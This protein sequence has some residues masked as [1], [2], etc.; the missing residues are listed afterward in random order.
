MDERT[1]LDRTTNARYRALTE[2]LD[3]QVE[4]VAEGVWTVPSKSNPSDFHIV[5]QAHGRLICDCAGA[6]AGQP[7]R[8]VSA[9]QL[10]IGNARYS[11][12]VDKPQSPYPE[13][14]RVPLV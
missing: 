9:V 3:R 1:R 6:K 5:H 8:H 10:W 2:R 13:R 14:K 4:R 11:H 7:C 12:R